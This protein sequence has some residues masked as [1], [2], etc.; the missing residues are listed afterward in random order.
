MR[1]IGV[2]T[3]GDGNDDNDRAILNGRV[4]GRKDARQPMFFDVDARWQRTFRFSDRMSLAIS[5][6]G[7]NMTKH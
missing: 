3:Q 6:E 4:V 5:A 1:V 7:F 2:D